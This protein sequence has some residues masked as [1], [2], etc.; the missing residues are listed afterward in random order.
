[1]L[2]SN[3]ANI[4]S[5]ITNTGI[6]KLAFAYKQNDFAFY[7]NGVQIGLDNGGNI[8]S[9]LSTIHLGHNNGSSQFNDRIRAVALYNT[10]LL[11]AELATL[12]TP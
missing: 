8:P 1:M 4:T 6:Y 2:G 10:R 7:I 12:T 5:T 9:N 3:V 11:D